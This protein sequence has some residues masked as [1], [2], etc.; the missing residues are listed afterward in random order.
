[1]IRFTFGN[2]NKI[3]S[4]IWRFWVQNSDVYFLT[5]IM[6]KA[7]KI[8]L[9]A[10]GIC[11]IAW[12]NDVVNVKPDRVIFKWKKG[13]YNAQ[14]FLPSIGILVPNLGYSDILDT[15]K[16]HCKDTKYIRIP[17]KNYK[18]IVRVF[19][20]KDNEGKDNIIAKL[21]KGSDLIY[22]E[23]LSN[24][25]YVLIFTWTE[26]LSNLELH[27]LKDEISKFNINVATEK[28]KENIYNAFA[29]WLKEPTTETQNQAVITIYPLRYSNLHLGK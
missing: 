22:T 3:L 15:N 14:K 27:L 12:N 8:S 9:H 19:F 4:P 26:H 13:N 17:K 10:S 16:E 29:F 18:A 24:K 28:D 25:E 7:W 2:K 5:R 23:Q 20:A 1:M 11:R 6:G 21:P